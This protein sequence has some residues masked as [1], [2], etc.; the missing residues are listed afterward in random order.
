MVCYFFPCPFLFFSQGCLTLRSDLALLP[1]TIQE[2]EEAPEAVL[3]P[4][5]TGYAASFPPPPCDLYEDRFWQAVHNVQISRAAE[6][7][8]SGP[9]LTLRLTAGIL[10][11]FS[12]RMG[13]WVRA[14]NFL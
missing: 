12:M 4:D 5:Q 13:C 6:L 14:F 9:F 8:H 2:E 1:T 10:L 7:S 3:L 11:R